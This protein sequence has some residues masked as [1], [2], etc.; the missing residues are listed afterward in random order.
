MAKRLIALD[1]GGSS[2][3]AALISF[4][5]R[6]GI[7]I[8]ARSS[9]TYEEMVGN[10]GKH[11]REVSGKVRVEKGLELLS[12][13]SRSKG[14][15]GIGISTTGTVDLTTGV[16]TDDQTED[17]IGVNWSEL[18]R[19]H[20][21]KSTPVHILNDGKASAWAEYYYWNSAS[22]N[23]LTIV[24]NPNQL[25]SVF[26]HVIIGSGIGS[27]II[28]HGQVH[29][30]VAG[31]AGEIGT[32][33]YCPEEPTVQRADIESLAS[34][35]GL[36]RIAQ[37]LA[38]Q[39]G[40]TPTVY[41][42]IIEI[43]KLYQQ[44]DEIAVRTIKLAAE[45]IGEGIVALINIIGPKAITIGGG[46]VERVEGYFNLIK[47]HVYSRAEK[48]ALDAL[49]IRPAKFG[50]MSGLLGAASLAYLKFKNFPY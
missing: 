23:Q 45:A 29:Y 25:P 6:D 27:G 26:A 7:A 41:G 9:L 12:V 40:K 37:Q 22:I 11:K 20:L 8:E 21:G 16:I 33:L 38:Q 10:W 3:K 42:S 46:T 44:N 5:K 31:V 32:L 48:P 19:N 18:I 15:D 43:S 34:S 17:Y 35:S 36:V 4:D 2:V 47:T 28:I 24:S 14:I 39:K 13:L 30:G 50:E 1:I 49:E